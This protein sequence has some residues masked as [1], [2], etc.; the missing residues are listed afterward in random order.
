[1]F[2]SL[3][4]LKPYLSQSGLTFTLRDHYRYQRNILSLFNIFQID[5]TS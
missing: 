2:R 4:T 1:M 3:W 5:I